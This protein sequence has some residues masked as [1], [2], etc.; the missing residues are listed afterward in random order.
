MDRLRNVFHL[1]IK[2]WRSLWRDKIMLGLILFSFSISVYVSGSS[3]PETLHMA[4][5]A[6]V[7]EDR[8]PLST[9]M[10][11][12]F[13]PPYFISP[14][15]VEQ[16]QIDPL[17]D[18]GDYTFV[19]DFP[20]GFQRDLLAG[21]EPTIQLNVDATRLMQAFLGASYIQAILTMEAR[22]FSQGGQSVE[23][24]V[25]L[26]VRNRFNP[27]LTQSWFGTVVK[28]IDNITMLSIILTGAALIREREHGTIEHLLVMPLTPLEIMLAKVWSMGLVVLLVSSASLV[29]LV[30]GLMRVP[31]EGSV[32]LFLVGAALHLF[33]TTSMGIFMATIARSMPQLGMLIILVL[34]PLQMLSGGSTPFENMPELV[35]AVMQAAPTTHFISLAQAILFRGAGLDIVWPRF[36]ALAAIGGLFFALAL[37]RFRKSIAGMA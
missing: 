33:A 3:I 21:R 11:A 7:D 1:G 6:I 19:L 32:P 20:P 9:R 10:V 22:A 17:M 4:P 27:S 14:A 28:V 25:A 8:S 2:E 24:P 29:L 13:Y 18:A 5:I 36:L 12:A 34:M 35:Q 15:M 16:R 26:Q 30:Q 23:L 37:R 31:I